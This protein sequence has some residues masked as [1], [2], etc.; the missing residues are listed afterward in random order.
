MSFSNNS[1]ENLSFSDQINGDIDFDDVINLKSRAKAEALTLI[2]WNCGGLTRTKAEELNVTL[3]DFGVDIALISETWFTRSDFTR[4]FE[5]YKMYNALQPSNKRRGGS[6]IL[7][8]NNLEHN[9]IKIIQ[10]DLFHTV[11]IQ[12][13]TDIGIFNV[14]SIYAPP[15]NLISAQNFL[16]LF[17]E[18]GQSFLL[19]GDFNSKDPIWES[20]ITNPKG[21]NLFEAV[22]K[23]DGNFIS[24]GKPTNFPYNKKHKPDIIDSF[25]LK[26]IELIHKTTSDTL[27]SPIT[28]IAKVSLINN[29][30]F[31]SNT[32]K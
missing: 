29:H 20:R 18:L 31:K 3:R 11:V 30:S 10:T 27:Q 9:L 24:P 21:E 6:S 25:V 2:A 28:G 15:N 17:G 12:L 22:K 19:G 23:I 5:G 32:H 1:N 8:K 16:D 13:Q 26:N 4:F 14:A 7:V